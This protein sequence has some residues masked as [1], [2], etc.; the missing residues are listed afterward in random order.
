M[1]ILSL[2]APAALPA[3]IVILLFYNLVS[4]LFKYL[5]KQHNQTILWEFLVNV[6]YY[7]LCQ[8]RITQRDRQWLRPREG[9]IID[10]DVIGILP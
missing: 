9:V 5:L 10:H 6:K 7:H 3:K 2:V 4:I 1:A 8:F